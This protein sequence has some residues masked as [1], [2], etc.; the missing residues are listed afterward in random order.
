MASQARVSGHIRVEER[1]SARVWIASFTRQ[2]DALIW[3]FMRFAD[4]PDER[5][6]T[7]GGGLNGSTVQATVRATDDLQPSDDSGRIDA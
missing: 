6:G 2:D 3:E 5:P 1:L 4:E 7:R